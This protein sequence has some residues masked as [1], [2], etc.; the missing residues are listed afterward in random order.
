MKTRL[1]LVIL[2]GF[3]LV[4]ASAVVLAQS[5]PTPAVSSILSQDIFVRSGPGRDYLPIGRLVAGN[6]VIPRSRNASSDWVLIEYGN[7]FGWIRRDL[8]AWTENIDLLPVLDLPDLTPSPGELPT[9]PPLT[10]LPTATPDASYVLLLPDAASGYVRAGPGRTY[11]RIGQF[12]TGDLVEPVGRNESGTWVLIRFNQGFGWIARNLVRWS[13]DVAGLPSL[14]ESNLTPSATFTPTFTPTATSTPT[15][16]FTPTPTFTATFTPT[17]TYTA[18]ATLTPTLT[19]T[20]SST[21]TPTSTPTYTETPT[22]PPTA[23]STATWTSTPSPTFTVTV[24]PSPTATQVPTLIP[25]ATFTLSATPMETL[26]AAQ[27][28]SPMPAASATTPPPT[29]TVTLAPSNT[30]SPTLTVTLTSTMTMTATVQPS[31]TYT[32]TPTPEPSPT[33]TSLPTHTATLR[34]TQPVA[35]A[36]VTSLPALSSS[37][38]LTATSSLIPTATAESE[39]TLSESPTVAVL[40]LTAT[41]AGTGVLPSDGGTGLTVEAVVGSA[42]LLGILVYG[43]FYW[44]GASEVDRFAQGFLIERCPVCGRGHLSVDHRSER[45]LG[46]PR[47]RHIVRC[48]ECRSVLRETAS[49]R[50]R[51]AVDPLENTELY[52]VYNGRELDEDQLHDLQAGGTSVNRLPAQPPTF[53]DDQNE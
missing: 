36:T 41:P 48:D 10:L 26:I 33:Q 53:L 12:F 23:T 18:T 30:P 42:A 8:A 21:P 43:W 4:L 27:I 29:A 25:S 44:R 46:V 6:T 19:V 9:R 49:R 28:P 13:V 45:L 50:W 17:L 7:G 5:T 38:M 20:P 32:S 3:S 51:Y 1:T 16:T 35:E 47:S 14:S 2:L 39:P 40:S 15:S 22:L 34:P 11:L 52:R 31:L 24:S 37:P